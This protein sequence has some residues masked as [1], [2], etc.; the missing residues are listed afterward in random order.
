MASRRYQILQAIKTALESIDG[1]GS[2]H[3]KVPASRI[4]YWQ[5]GRSGDEL[6]G[7]RFGMR[8]CI[9]IEARTTAAPDSETVGEYQKT[10]T[11]LIGCYLDG[12]VDELDRSEAEEDIERALLSSFS[13]STLGGLCHN[14][15][16]WTTYPYDPDRDDLPLD[17][18]HFELVLTYEE[19]VGA[20][21]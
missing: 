20:P 11:V 14:L 21:G 1:T 3:L 12:T 6:E 17:G 9:V 16:T 2:Y 13:S 19:T 7:N 4:Q 5:A 8:P 15:P 10:L 18:I